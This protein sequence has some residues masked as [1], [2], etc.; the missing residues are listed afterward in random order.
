MNNLTAQAAILIKL[1][2][3]LKS[4]PVCKTGYPNNVSVWNRHKKAIPALIQ[5]GASEEEAAFMVSEICNQ[6][7]RPRRRAH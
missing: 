6:Y 5:A 2:T 4:L 7:Y 1:S 3:E